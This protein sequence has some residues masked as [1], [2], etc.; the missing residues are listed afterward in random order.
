[1]G[2]HL[3][4]LLLAPVV[5][6]ASSQADEDVAERLIL[7]GVELRRVGLHQEALDLFAKAHARSPSGRSLAQMALAEFSLK[8]HADAESHLATAL[9]TDS[10]WVNVPGNRRV[11]EQTLRALRS[12][13]AVVNVVGPAGTE[14]VM[15]GRSVGHLPLPGPVHMEAGPVRIDLTSPEHR[16]WTVVMTVA[17]GSQVELIASPQSRCSSPPPPIEPPSRATEP[18]PSVRP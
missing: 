11:L 9:A 15:N 3:F 7:C 17:G 1:M 13:I 18:P 16:W 12:K 4:V 6:E 2:V 5:A 14:V 10:R 8:R